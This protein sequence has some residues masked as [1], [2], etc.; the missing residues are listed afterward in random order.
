VL[1]VEGEPWEH[2]SLGSKQEFRLPAV[3]GRGECGK[4]HFVPPAKA[5]AGSDF[6]ETWGATF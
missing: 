4:I 5:W 1:H 2:Q 6:Q 3:R